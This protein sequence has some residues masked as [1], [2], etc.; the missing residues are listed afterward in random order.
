VGE[1]NEKTTRKKRRR[2]NAPILKGN[3]RMS[4][5][6]Y[7]DIEGAKVLTPDEHQRIAKSLQKLGKLSAQDLTDDERKLLLDLSK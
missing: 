5:T 6:K 4:L 3:K 7:A 1:A 2:I